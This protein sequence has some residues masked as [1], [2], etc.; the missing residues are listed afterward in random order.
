MS[1]HPALTRLSSLLVLLAACGGDV[2]AGKL[3]NPA[4]VKRAA[5]AKAAAPA[6]SG[7]ADETPADEPIA[8]KPYEKVDLKDP[9]A[10]VPAMFRPV[11][12]EPPLA[13]EV[14]GLYG[15]TLTLGLLGESVDTFNPLTSNEATSSELKSLIFDSLVGYDNERWEQAPLLAWKWEVSPDDLVWTFHLRKGVRFSDGEELTADDVVFTFMKTVF[16]E[17]VANSDVDGFKVGGAPLPV[18][19][20]VDDHTVRATCSVV[21]ATFLIAVGNVSIVPEHRWRDTVTGDQPAYNSAM[22]PE[23]LDAI[24]GT[25]PYR[26]VSY[27]PGEK[28][29]YQPNPW[30][31]RTT[32]SGQR[33]PFPDRFV[34]KLVK[35]NST[36]SLQFLGDGFDFID[37]IQV[38]D[39]NQF[40]AKEKE[41]WFDL[42]RL[43]T[44]LNVTWL[45]FNQNP[46]NR[47]DGTPKV[48]PYK[49]AWFQDVRFRRAISHAI[50]R[51]L[52][53]K[54]ILEGRGAAIYGDTSRANRAWYAPSTRFPYDPAKASA[55]LDRMGLSRRD[56][57]GI[58][59]DSAGRRVSFDLMTNAENALRCKVID[60]VKRFC[61]VVGVDVQLRQV[62]FQ[63]I[64]SQLDDVHT[65]EAIVLGWA[66]GV[67]PDPLNGKNIHLSSG[68]L[69]VHYPM[70]EKPFREWEAATDA[71]IGQMSQ[72]TSEA[73]RKSW[74][75]VFLEIN[76]LQQSTIFLYSPNEYAATRKRVGNVRPSLLRPQ[77]WWNFD[78]LWARDGK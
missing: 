15:G 36:R 24:V 48:L 68:R 17:R 16:N 51:D 28:I 27:R 73:E 8:V 3:V 62:A 58:R 45:S 1:K 47:P 30:S 5:D 7:A 22:G 67:P 41:G 39:Y 55:L 12:V 19:E 70:Q 37:G 26:I 65:W 74:W 35:D 34:A 10:A 66:S 56:A 25:G 32:A 78:E 44:S 60:Q 2:P 75:K 52:L 18:F 61:A 59:L 14:Q 72:L 4:D 42:H 29:E 21:N 23:N 43:G 69:H 53:V 40:D 6:G 11:Q 77:T 20:K 38:S 9:R 54:N 57:D 31:W 64:S 33:L 49:L 50:D 71:V 76:A 13:S 46:N 63:E